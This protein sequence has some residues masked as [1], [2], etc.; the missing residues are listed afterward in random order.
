MCL[1]ELC[2]IRLF[3]NR[4]ILKC[5]F[6]AF[7]WTQL[8]STECSD[9]TSHPATAHKNVE[10]FISHCGISG[11]HEAL[12]D[13]VPM[14]FTPFFVDQMSNAAL[15]EKLGVGLPLDLFSATKKKVLEALNAIINDTR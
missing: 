1:C 9:K 8:R 2:R 13:G 12:T 4:I 5:I 3:T 6:S 7:D 10:A 15:L 14:I 11:T